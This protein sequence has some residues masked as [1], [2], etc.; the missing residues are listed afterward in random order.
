M[1]CY[2]V[3]RIC[4]QAY[5]IYYQVYRIFYQVY[6]IC[7]QVYRICYKLYRI[8]YQVY[9]ICYWLYRQVS[10]SLSFLQRSREKRG[11]GLFIRNVNNVIVY[12]TSSNSNNEYTP[13]N[14]GLFMIFYKVSQRNFNKHSTL[15]LAQFGFLMFSK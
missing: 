13:F 11:Y 12:T 5:R 15:S 9:R 7:C 8:C 10:P 1:I 3:Y 14:K 6:I 4:Y 2:K